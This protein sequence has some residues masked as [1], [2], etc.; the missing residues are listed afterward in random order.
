[1]LLFINSPACAAKYQSRRNSVGA[2]L[3]STPRI[4]STGCCIAD[5]LCE[6][7]KLP[8]I[9]F[10]ESKGKPVGSW[11]VSVGTGEIPVAVG[12]LSVATRT[13]P[14]TP[15]NRGNPPPANPA[16][17]SYLG[18]GV[19]KDGDAAKIERV[20]PESPADKAGLKVADKILSIHGKAI[21]T[22]ESVIAV[23]AP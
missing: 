22:Q 2:R 4:L 18:I 1:M 14:P 10:T 6:A 13:P 19:S 23:L 20:S 12:V 3:V 9:I 11:V 21:T 7:T 15:G 16:N 8:A 5:F 17:A